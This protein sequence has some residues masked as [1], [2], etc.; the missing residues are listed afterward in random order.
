MI[1]NFGTE[2]VCTCIDTAVRLTTEAKTGTTVIKNGNMYDI[3]PMD[4]VAGV[5]GGSGQHYSS[6]V[7]F[8]QNSAIP[9][10]AIQYE[11][12]V[13]IQALLLVAQ[14]CILLGLVHLWDLYMNRIHVQTADRVYKSAASNKT[15]RWIKITL[16]FIV[17]IV[18]MVRQTYDTD[19]LNDTNQKQQGFRRC[20][21][22]III[23]FAITCT[24]LW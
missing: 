5:G 13:C 12:T 20:V 19:H 3:K 22:A 8:C 1:G 24:L 23:M 21:F 2:S 15:R 17:V 7:G 6:I 14:L 18:Y 16:S 11:G 10:H 4:K 9:I